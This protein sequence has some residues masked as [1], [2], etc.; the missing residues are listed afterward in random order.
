MERKE[1]EKKVREMRRMIPAYSNGRKV[2]LLSEYSEKGK[3]VLAAANHYEGRYLWQVYDRPSAEKERIFRECEEMFFNSR[4][5]ESFSICSHNCQS[6]SVSWLSD[7]GLTML[8]RNTEYIV[9]FN[10]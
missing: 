9:V 7:D 5:G 4:H 2:V 3:A 8:T 1:F 10:E 6:F